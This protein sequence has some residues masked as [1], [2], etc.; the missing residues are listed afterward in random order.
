M[1]KKFF[2][3]LFSLFKKKETPTVTIPQEPIKE[4]PK[5]EVVISDEVY[6]FKRAKLVAIAEEEAKKGLVWELPT[7]NKLETAVKYTK[8]FESWFGE[9][10]FAWCAAFVTWCLNK[11]GLKLGIQP[12]DLKEFKY[13]W[14]LVETYQQWAIKHGYYHD[15]DGKYVPTAGDIVIFDWEQIDINQPDTDWDDHIGIHLRMDGK[16]YICA[17]GNSS[18][19]TGVFTRYSKQIQGWISLPERLK[20]A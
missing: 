10:R 15:N 3:W 9:G 17:E 7:A 6:G 12:K 14:A 13:T 8:P 18:N 19:R 5:P 20:E 2:D 1:F 4:V 11:S 16:N